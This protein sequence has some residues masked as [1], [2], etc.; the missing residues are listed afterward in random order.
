MLSETEP[1]EASAAKLSFVVVDLVASG[2]DAEEP[3]RLNA[4]EPQGGACRT[5]E[6]PRTCVGDL[7]RPAPAAVDAK[8][9]PTVVDTWVGDRVRLALAADEA[10]APLK[11]LRCAVLADG[12]DPT[13]DGSECRA[14]G[15][16]D[17]KVADPD[18]VDPSIE[19]VRVCAGCT[20]D[21]GCIGDCGVWCD[22]ELCN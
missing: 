8:D 4:A 20:C 12:E 22:S 14:L 2:P 16:A 3:V 18:V 17:A 15:R 1:Q 5:G 10:P 7:A 6:V 9:A 21:C 19:P 11:L 13:R